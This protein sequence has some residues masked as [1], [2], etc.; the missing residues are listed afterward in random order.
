MCLVASLRHTF[1]GFLRQRA[2]AANITAAF[3]TTASYDPV[4][5]NV[6]GDLHTVACS[7]A[8][9]GLL[10]KGFTTF[11]SL[12]NFAHIGGAPAVGGWN[13]A[14]CGTCWALTFNGKTI[15]VLAIDHSDP[16]FNI[17]LSALNELT[18]KQAVAL[19]RVT[20]DAKQA[21]ASQCG[22]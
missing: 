10:T 19:G 20:V 15:N 12:P 22:L 14:S 16:G 6:N 17:A 2:L 9:N 8:P 3:T 13:S 7:D 1:A 4:Y 5:D 21:A 11:E 18:N